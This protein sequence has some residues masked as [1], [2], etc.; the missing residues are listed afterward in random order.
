VEAFFFFY[1]SCIARAASSPPQPTFPRAAASRHKTIQSPR[2]FDTS[3]PP[4]NLPQ[5][6]S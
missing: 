4:S 6:R 1:F 3:S 2:A 5:P